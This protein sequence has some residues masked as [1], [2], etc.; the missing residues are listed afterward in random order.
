MNNTGLYLSERNV[1]LFQVS[2]DRSNACVVWKILV[3]K[4]PGACYTQTSQLASRA[5][6]RRR[7][8]LCLL[9]NPSLKEK[10]VKHPDFGCHVTRSNQGSISRE[11]EREPWER[12]CQKYR[13]NDKNCELITRT[14]LN[15]SSHV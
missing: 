7:R 14:F 15:G 5:F 12:S 8:L 6:L 9:Y 11:E 1:Q 3:T 13:S 2:N 4:L 10:F